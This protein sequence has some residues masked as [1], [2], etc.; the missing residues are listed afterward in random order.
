MEIDGY[1][2][3]DP[4]GCPLSKYPV[5]L[6]WDHN[7]SQHILT[8]EAESQSYGIWNPSAVNTHQPLS[9]EE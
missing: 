4:A 7:K 8:I 5:G 6:R 2:H 9:L 1:R 3:P